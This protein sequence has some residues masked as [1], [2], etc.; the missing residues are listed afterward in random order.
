ML[1]VASLLGSVLSQ[2]CFSM[3]GQASEDAVDGVIRL[4]MVRAYGIEASPDAPAIEAMRE[5]TR[6]VLEASAAAESRGDA[7]SADRD[8]KSVV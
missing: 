3:T 4:D 8:R 6:K 1:L 2:P 7:A 5:A